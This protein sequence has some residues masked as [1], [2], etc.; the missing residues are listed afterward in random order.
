MQPHQW[1]LVPVH[2]VHGSD[3]LSVNTDEIAE[4]AGM[5]FVSLGAA[6]AEKLGVSEGDGVVVASGGTEVSLEVRIL[7]RVAKNCIGFGAGLC[8]NPAICRRAPGDSG[9]G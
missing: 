7:Q 8:R 3:E 9:G 4:L 5:G 2:Q 1:Q 6:V